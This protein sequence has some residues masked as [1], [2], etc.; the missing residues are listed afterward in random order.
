MRR[1]RVSAVVGTKEPDRVPVQLVAAPPRKGA[2]TKPRIVVEP[3]T[4]TVYEPPAVHALTAAPP[5]SR[6]VNAKPPVTPAL[7]LPCVGHRR[8]ES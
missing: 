4:V 3:A 2:A 5:A 8:Q 1:T 6:T 7:F